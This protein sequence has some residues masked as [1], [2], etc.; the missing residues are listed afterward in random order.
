MRAL[1]NVVARVDGKDTMQ[2]WALVEWKMGK[3]KD[4]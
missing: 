2:L 4:S 3:L 1:G